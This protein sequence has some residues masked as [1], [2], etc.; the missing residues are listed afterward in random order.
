MVLVDEYGLSL[1]EIARHAGLGTTTVSRI[2]KQATDGRASTITQLARSVRTT[3]EIATRHRSSSLEETRLL[4]TIAIILDEPIAGDSVWYKTSARVTHPYVHIALGYRLYYI[5]VGYPAGFEDGRARIARLLEDN[6]GGAN[7]AGTSLFDVFGDYDLLIRIWNT[8]DNLYRLVQAIRNE[9]IEALDVF[10][11]TRL[12]TPFQRSCEKGMEFP[13]LPESTLF[14]DGNRWRISPVYQDSM[15]RVRNKEMVEFFV[16]FS[17]RLGMESEVFG[18]LMGRCDE[19]SSSGE[20]QGGIAFEDYAVYAYESENG[21]G[22]LFTGFTRN[23]HEM[24]PALFMLLGHAGLREL[25]ST[26]MIRAGESDIADDQPSDG[27]LRDCQARD[28]VALHLQT[29]HTV[30]GIDQFRE[31]G[32][33]VDDLLT[34][35]GSSDVAP[36][37]VAYHP[38]YWWD[39]VRDVQNVVRNILERRSDAVLSFFMLA[40]TNLEADLRALLLTHFGRF[41]PDDITPKDLPYWILTECGILQHENLKALISKAS[42]ILNAIVILKAKETE[43]VAKAI[44]SSE[45][46]AVELIAKL[47]AVRSDL[48]PVRKALRFAKEEFRCAAKREAHIMLGSIPRIIDELRK[49]EHVPSGCWEFLNEGPNAFMVDWQKNLRAAAEDRNQL[50]HGAIRDIGT[51]VKGAAAWRHLL[52]NYIRFYPQYFML[53][54]NL[55]TML[56]LDSESEQAPVKV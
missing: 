30:I 16:F 2:L 37:L 54:T 43:I 48:G 24:Q 17:C 29:I 56:Q 47:S 1:N 28:K 55:S 21:A 23:W 46:A 50:M 15:A 41:A 18:H 14:R 10:R 12:S 13:I 4:E 38:D 32:L 3:V 49:R 36:K 44:P 22:C 27:M 51:T 25:K 31:R 34:I 39:F 9:Q 8:P 33:P 53:R 7:P 26:T 45:L 11:V 6:T 40:Y 35:L 42:E 52:P 19:I 5:R 20:F